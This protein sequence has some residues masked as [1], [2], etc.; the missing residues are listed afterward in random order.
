L[1]GVFMEKTDYVR[2]SRVS[3]YL[4]I[5]AVVAVAALAAGIYFL[6]TGDR[7]KEP[8]R[9]TYV[10]SQTERSRGFEKTNQ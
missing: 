5:I 2:K 9:G 10:I 6:M 7:R 8:N 1:R 3:F 4:I